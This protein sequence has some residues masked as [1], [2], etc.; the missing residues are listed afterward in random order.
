MRTALALAALLALAACG[1][2]TDASEPD[3]TSTVEA[4][5]PSA[6]GALDTPDV[7]STGAGLDPDAP[8]APPALGD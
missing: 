4:G 5:G 8:A 2:E 3:V 7:D 6:D 1:A